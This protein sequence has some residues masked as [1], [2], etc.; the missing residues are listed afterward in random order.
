[1]RLRDR[2]QRRDCRFHSA[3]FGRIVLGADNNEVVIHDQTT[4]EQF[5]FGDRFLLQVWRMGQNH[6]GIAAL[7]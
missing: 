4:I 3:H 5:T 2:A 7:G 6:I 1:L